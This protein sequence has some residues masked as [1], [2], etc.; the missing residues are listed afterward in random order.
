MLRERK[1]ASR[2]GPVALAPAEADIWIFAYGSLLWD[3]G[4][5]YQACAPAT[6]FGY[7]RAF[8][9]YSYIYRGT[10]A[11]PG[12]VLGLDRGGSCRGR[13]YRVAGARAAAVLAYLEERERTIYV[14]ERR[15][16][17]VRLSGEPVP[18]YAYIADRSHPQ[19]TG[20][21]T[22]EAAADIIRRGHGQRGPNR[23][24]L[25][26][27][28]LHLRELGVTDHHLEALLRLVDA[29]PG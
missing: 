1:S 2:A 16:C 6:L 15:L 24:Y 21:L 20:P 25:A 27:T 22:L 10:R 28:V 9:V 26:N 13:V 19:Y 7:H 5:R 11:R 8:C 3:P 23:D 4:F 17:R 29:R 12:L 18:A 14:Y